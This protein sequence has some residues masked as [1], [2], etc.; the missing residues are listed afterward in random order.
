MALY[1]IAILGKPSAEL[2]QQ[3]IKGVSDALTHFDL[4]LGTDVLIHENPAQFAPSQRTCS[5][6]VYFGHPDG[7]LEDLTATI[8]S[9]QV[10]VLPVASSAAAVPKEIPEC[11]RALNCLTLDLQSIDRVVTGTLECLGL[12]RR[13]R[14]VFISYRREEATPAALQLFA[15]LSARGYDVFV[16][17]HGV[18]TAVDFQETLWHRLCDVDVV[19]MLDTKS[20]FDSR[21]TSEEFG[22][23]LAKNIGVLRVQ[24]PDSSP[25][26]RTQTCSR[27]ELIPSEIGV[28]GLLDATAIDRIGDQL[29]MFR[30]MSLAVRRL[31]FITRLQAE[32]KA[33]SGRVL[34]VGPHF[35]TRI[36]LPGNKLVTVQPVL[37]VPDATTAQEA[38]ELAGSDRAAV[39][40]DHIGMR[41]SWLT[42]LEWLEKSISRARWVR[43]SQ[44][45][46]DLTGI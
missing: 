2:R 16:D 1:E 9:L 34:G 25:D 7:R 19:I 46:R 31:G 44:V 5:V 30:A 29:E 13:Q 42:H 20:Y 11:L 26:P 45:N 12:L 8:D 15:A 6:A 37:G 21:W 38:I 4:V 14:K 33:I 17:T 40:F 41:R 43:L 36:E 23:A 3:L 39:L 10:A 35:A 32:V 27:V 24:W 18:Q 22:K 28:T